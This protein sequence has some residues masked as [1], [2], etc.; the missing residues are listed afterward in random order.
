MIDKIPAHILEVNNKFIAAGYKIYLVGGCVRDLSCGRAIKDWDFTTNANPSEILKLFPNGF[1]DNKFGTVG[2]PIK[3]QKSKI[4]DQ[5]EEGVYEENSVV[6]V[7]TFRTETAYMD[8]RHPTEVKWGKTVEEDLSRRDFT[9]NAMA[10]EVQDVRLKTVDSRIIDPYHGQE[11]IK[12]KLIRAVGDA[13]LR[14]KEDALRLM[15]A[16]RFATQLA[17]HI[18][19]KTLL[20]IIEDAPLLSEI[21]KERIRDEFMKIL[22]SDYPYEGVMLLKNTNLLKYIIPQLLE[23]VDFSQ[24]RPGR[25]H[26]TDVFT[27]NLLALKYCP[28]KNPLVRLATL[29]HDIAKPKVARRD[30]EGYVI[31]YNHEVASAKMAREIADNLRFSKKE[32]EKISTLIRWHMFT[33]DEH[34]TDAAVRRFIRRIGVENVRDMMDL[35]IGDRLG[36]GTQ[37]AESWRLKLFKERI[38]KQLAPAPFSISDLAI[39]GHDIIKELQIKPGP[40]IGELLQKLFE[41]VDEDLSRNNKDYLLKRMKEM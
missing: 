22:A 26:K 35:R 34:I 13:N 33:V 25:H 32:K 27:H 7:T 20:A 31:F 30:G 39:D 23:G 17:F 6:E 2:I 36:G 14:F 19:E 28:S 38:E 24:E 29:I 21:S 8:R 40:K 1:Y 9:I 12:N 4:K 5:N 11:D 37:T 41:E 3:N 15:R 10:M 16:I 18:D